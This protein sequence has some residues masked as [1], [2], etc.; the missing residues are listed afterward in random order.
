[1]PTF[2]LLTEHWLT[3]TELC[4]IQEYEVVSKYCREKGYGGTVILGYKNFLADYVTECVDQYD[5]LIVPNH[6]EFSLGFIKFFNIFLLCVY[7]PPSGIPAMFLE[8]LESLLNKFPPSA[9]IILGGDLNINY[10]DVESCDTKSLI[11]LLHSFD[12]KVLVNEPTRITNKS[13]TTIDYICSNFDHNELNCHVLPSGLSDHEALSAELTFSCGTTKKCH[14]QR[15]IFSKR[16][17][18]AF[19][20]LASQT[21]WNQCLNSPDPVESFQT[22]VTF[23]LRTN[24]FLCAK[25]K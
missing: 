21:N 5:D 8:S 15:R 17:F 16:N 14:V 1:M 20:S 23:I 9:N 13:A 24:V 7:R 10:D 4:H 2:V 11:N 3:E 18:D 22:G 12:L 19:R 6:F 25:L